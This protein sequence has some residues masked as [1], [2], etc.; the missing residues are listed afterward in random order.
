MAEEP[1][2]CFAC[3]CLVRPGQTYDL[4]IEREVLCADCALTEGGIRVRDDLAVEVKR[5]RLLI[6]CGETEVTMA[7]CRGDVDAVRS[8]IGAVQQ[9]AGGRPE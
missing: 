2:P 4:T 6:L 1:E 8:K 7:S 3:F 5:D 9:R